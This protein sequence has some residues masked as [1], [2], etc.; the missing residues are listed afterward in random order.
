MSFTETKAWKYLTL[1]YGRDLDLEDLQ[2]LGNT[3]CLC[4]ESANEQFDDVEDA[5]FW[6]EQYWETFK[7][8]IDHQIHIFSEDG[9]ELN[10]TPERNQQILTDDQKKSSIRIY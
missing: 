1:R 4:F 8:V 3:I 9:D 2:H 7:P 5:V 10:F 6:F